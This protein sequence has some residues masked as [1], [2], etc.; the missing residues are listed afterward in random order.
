MQL[1][2]GGT[3]SVCDMLDARCGARPCRAGMSVGFDDILFRRKR[4]STSW[5]RSAQPVTFGDGRGGYRAADR[6]VR[7]RCRTRGQ[8]RVRAVEI[9][10]SHGYII[11]NFLAVDQP[12]HGWLKRLAGAAGATSEGK[13]TEA[14]RARDLD[15]RLPRM[16][17]DRCG[18]SS[19]SRQVDN[20]RMCASMRKVAE[21]AG[22]NAITA[23]ANHNYAAPGALLG[24]WLPASPAPADPLRLSREGGRRHSGHHGRTD[25]SATRR[26]RDRRGQVRFH[27]H[28]ASSWLIELCQV[29]RA[30]ASGTGLRPCIYCYTCLS[31]SI[32]Q[33]PLRC[34]VNGDLGFETQNLLGAGR[35]AAP[36][37]RGGRR[38]TR[39][40]E[41]APPDC[42]ATRWCCSKRAR[43]WAARR[44]S[45]LI[46]YAPNGDFVEWLKARLSD[47]QVDV[48]LGAKGHRGDDP[49]YKPDAVIVATGA[50]RRAP[51]IKGRDQPHVHDGESLRAPCSWERK[52]VAGARRPWVSAPRD[53]RG[54]GW[55]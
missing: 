35:Q 38:R 6:L 44:A 33:Q 37:G 13:V 20:P 28:G 12:A 7:R 1:H 51:P 16:V 8:N 31:Q 26:R 23:T 18:G 11:A 52:A 49:R 54:A 46:A 24:S 3:S 21:A 15:P 17:Q 4:R 40:M 34:S 36:P 42:A 29:W 48:R 30:A 43:S 50:I 39:G 5:R 53:G 9:H 45:P 41:A 32:L 55:V 47:A 25:R 14:V 10:G 19:T 22:A 27:G 2:F